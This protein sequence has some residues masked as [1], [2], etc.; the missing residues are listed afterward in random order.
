MRG[1]HQTAATAAELCTAVGTSSEL[2]FHFWHS[3][4]EPQAAAA[5]AVVVEVRTYFVRA[6][7]F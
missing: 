7:S 1:Q 5:R 4:V 3:A 6:R 2:C